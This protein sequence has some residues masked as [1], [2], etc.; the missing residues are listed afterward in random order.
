MSLI[1]LANISKS[2][3]SGTSKVEALKEVSFTVDRGEMLAI[4]G[5]SGSGKTTLVN[6][7]AGFLTPDSGKVYLKDVDISTYSDGQR[8]KLRSDFWGYIAQDY[9]LIPS[10]TA[11][12]NIEIPLQYTDKVKRSDRKKKVYEVA[13]KLG[14][15]ALLYKKISSLSGGEK[16]RVAIARAI[17]NDQEVILADEP[18]GALDIENRDHVVEA[19]RELQSVHDK[20][21]ILITHDLEVAYNCDR[22]IRL[23]GGYLV[24]DRVLN[25]GDKEDDYDLAVAEDAYRDS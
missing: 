21:V 24:E 22:I 9:L 7:I 20:T 16:Q 15:E 5:P 23:H 17:V 25:S 2:Y 13:K 3:K 10:D 6:I 11:Y 4:V 18:T 8:A 19:L 14:I 12:Q 1:E